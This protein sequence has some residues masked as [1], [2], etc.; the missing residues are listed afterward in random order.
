V[1]GGCAD[2]RARLLAYFETLAD[3]LRGVRVCCGDWSRILGPSPTHRMGLTGVFLDPPYDVDGTDYGERAHGLAA[4]VRD[5]AAANGEHPLMR[6]ALCGY[7]DEAHG[8]FLPDTW[9]CV[10]WRPGGGYNNLGDGANRDRERIWFSPAC[11]IDQ[12]DLFGG[13]IAAEKKDGASPC[14]PI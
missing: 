5:W 8:A 3:R 12:P 9:H 14:N 13:L 1:P 6:I 10:A 11:I 7:A 2:R 4:A